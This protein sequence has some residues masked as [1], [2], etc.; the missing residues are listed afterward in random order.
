VLY[1]QTQGLSHALSAWI[2]QINDVPL[3]E[4]ITAIPHSHLF[5]TI[6]PDARIVAYF[7]FWKDLGKQGEGAYFIPTV[8]QTSHTF[9]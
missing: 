2:Q 8:A 7:G 9:S 5:G 4:P 6:C 3:R 1:L